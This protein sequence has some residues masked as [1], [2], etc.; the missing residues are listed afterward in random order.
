MDVP[1][2]ISFFTVEPKLWLEWLYWG[3]SGVILSWVSTQIS[4]LYSGRTETLQAMATVWPTLIEL[5][6][7]ILIV[8]ITLA[9]LVY[10]VRFETP[11]LAI[12]L[13]QTPF[14]SI[15]LAFVLGYL[16]EIGRAQLRIFLQLY[17]RRF[18]ER[19]LGQRPAS[20]EGAA[21]YIALHVDPRLAAAYWKASSTEAGK[22]GHHASM[23]KRVG[24]TAT[25]YLKRV[26][27][28][29]NALKMVYIAQDLLGSKDVLVEIV[30]HEAF[31]VAQ[32]FWSDSLDQ[33]RKSY[34]KAAKVME[35]L[36][37][38]GEAAFGDKDG[39][40]GL[41]DLKAKNKV[42]DLGKFVPLYDVIPPEQPQ[43]AAD[44]IAMLRQAVFLVKDWFK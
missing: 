43:K 22:P 27:F 18:R 34:Q 1:T 8:L 40:L 30:A 11:G 33:E 37:A 3:S 9:I 13:T 12:Q 20:G 19:Y 5:L 14:Y 17:L 44:K 16:S 26:G 6:K 41:N 24:Y 36:K 4:M 7:R 25:S 2:A 32:G 23:R 42:R 35:E 29:V 21:D 28:T 10:G 31:H 39:W 15:L 38:R